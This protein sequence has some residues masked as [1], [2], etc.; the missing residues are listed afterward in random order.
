[1][2]RVLREL[3]TFVQISVTVVLQVTVILP[4]LGLYMA[5]GLGAHVHK[6]AVLAQTVGSQ[7]LVPE[8]GAQAGL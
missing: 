6:T 5:A 1:M 3:R 2:F 4:G 7:S 8:A